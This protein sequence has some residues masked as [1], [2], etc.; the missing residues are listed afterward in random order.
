MAE[1]RS[2]LTRD[3]AL[4]VAIAQ[5]VVG[6]VAALSFTA[7]SISHPTWY[8]WLLAVVFLLQGV[9]GALAIHRIRR[10]P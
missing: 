5:C 4:R 1:N 3:Q 6:T 9:L 2:G 8:R 10:Q 7:L